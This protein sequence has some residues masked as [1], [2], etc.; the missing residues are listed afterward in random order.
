MNR[1]KQLT[2]GGTL[3][4][5]YRYTAQGPRASKTVGSTVTH[6]LYDTAGHLI[7][8]A[9]GATGATTREYVWI[10]DRVGVDLHRA[11]HCCQKWFVALK[12]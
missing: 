8:E 5:S 9:N 12:G 3:A 4:G 6:Y 1:L 10:P 2:S 11:R 7:A